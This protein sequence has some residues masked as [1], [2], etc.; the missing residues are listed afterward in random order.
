MDIIVT[1][2][3]AKSGI[4]VHQPCYKGIFGQFALRHLQGIINQPTLTCLFGEMIY[5]LEQIYK[6]IDHLLTPPP[7]KKKERTKSG[8][9]HKLE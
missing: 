8:L 5:T 9:T 1:D 7:P 6:K 4:S 3:Q 2:L